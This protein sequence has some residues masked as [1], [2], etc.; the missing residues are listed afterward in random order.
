[1]VSLYPAITV[2]LAIRFLGEKLDAIKSIAILLSIMGVACIAQPSFL[3]GDSRLIETTPGSVSG[4]EKMGY[5]T[6]VLASFCG[7]CVLILI[8][9]VGRDGHTT[10]LLFSWFFF[11]SLG[12]LVLYLFSSNWVLPAGDQWMDI[13]WMILF[14]S[15]GHFLMNYAGRFCPAG[16]GSIMSSTDV[17][18]AYL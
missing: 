10:H 12:A 17:V 4:C 7:G 9:M 2:V 6:A 15:A 5:M 18:W 3:F 13:L 16:A 11:T 14:G 8:R 1:L